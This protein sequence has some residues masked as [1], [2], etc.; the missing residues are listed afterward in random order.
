[1]SYILDALRKSDAQRRLGQVPDLDS[2]PAPVAGQARPRRRGLLVL[3]VVLVL[4]AVIGLGLSQ[5]QP[6]EAWRMLVGTSGE[7]PAE[8]EPEPA[9]IADPERVAR[10]PNGEL[11]VAA[12]AEPE[13]PASEAVA[14]SEQ[15]GLRR[16]SRPAPQPHAP[17]VV[18]EGGRE[19]LVETAEEAQRLIEAEEAAAAL[20]EAYRRQTAEDQAEPPATASS[21]EPA[22]TAPSSD[23][24][25]WAPESPQ[26]VS[27]WDLPLSIRRELPELSLSIH[28]FSAEPGGRFVLINGERRLE[29][30]DLGEGASL[31]EIRRDGALIDFRDYRF[32]LEP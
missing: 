24:P 21:R 32:L 29:G 27:V 13:A 14:E 19:R 12:P 16:I 11:S 18:P 3:T 25:S 17:V 5:T 26:F 20:A 4:A 23:D 7:A 9:T 28:V 15:R 1:M 2:A 6:R 31:V 22:G 10:E 8:A 30:D